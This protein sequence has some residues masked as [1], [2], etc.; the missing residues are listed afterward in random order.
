MTH[1][2]DPPIYCALAHSASEMAAWPSPRAAGEKFT[3]QQEQLARL[4]PLVPAP[5]VSSTA[6]LVIE[7]FQDRYPFEPFTRLKPPHPSPA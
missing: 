2:D 4:E 7:R 5:P 6:A 1:A 3:P